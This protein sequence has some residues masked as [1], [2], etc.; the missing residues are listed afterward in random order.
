MTTGQAAP[1]AFTPDGFFTI[2]MQQKH[3][4][5]NL[6]VS[7]RVRFSYT[8]LDEEGKARTVMQP[9]LCFSFGNAE[10]EKAMPMR[11]KQD[12]ITGTAGVAMQ[13]LFAECAWSAD[14]VDKYIGSTVA[15][16]RD[17]LLVKGY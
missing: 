15:D 11:V 16:L 7:T 9:V 8:Y 2:A 6:H 14:D 5:A 4:I 12:W 13:R 10:V 3:G 17:N 1:S